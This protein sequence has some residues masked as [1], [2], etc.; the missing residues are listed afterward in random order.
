MK[1]RSLPVAAALTATAALL[2]TAC[3]GGDADS[4]EN[5]KIAGADQGSA[6]PTKSPSPSGAPAADKPDGVD[7]SLPKDMNLTFDWEKPEDKNE[8]AAMEDAANF[9]RAIYRG[10]DKRTSNVAAVTAYATGEGLHYAKT[11]IDSRVDGG[12][13]ATGTRRHYEASTRA[14]SNGNSVEVAFCVDSSKFYGKEVKTGKIL[15]SEPSIAD[16]DHFRVI[17]VKYPTGAG[18]W[19]ASKVFVKTKA[20]ECR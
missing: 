14:T 1:R 16:Y 20:E 3:G 13:T 10:V 11:Q 9:F 8:A 18:L 12:W 6:Q 17:M 2:L 7:V 4:G 5:D 15:R 19:Q